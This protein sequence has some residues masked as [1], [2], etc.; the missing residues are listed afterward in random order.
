M[1]PNMGFRRALV[2]RLVRNARPAVSGE[3]DKKDAAMAVN[4]I[5]FVNEVRQEVSKVTWPT[6]REVWITTILVGI[7]VTVAS[8]FFLLADQILGSFVK[9]ILSLGS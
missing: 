1:R 5:E 7:M 6:F 8:L 4:P 2:E 9:V 3:T